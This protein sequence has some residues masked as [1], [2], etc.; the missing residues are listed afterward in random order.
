LRTFE[1]QINRVYSRRHSLLGEG[2]ETVALKPQ[3]AS[4]FGAAGGLL[5]VSVQPTTEAF[6]SGLR[7]GDV[8]ESIN[9]RPVYVTG[10]TGAGGLYFR[11]DKPQTCVVIRNKEKISLTIQYS[12]E[13]EPDKP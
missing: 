6:K 2:I 10:A 8:I 9:G 7:P 1:R 12:K 5:V 11:N 3:A 13:Q 4:R